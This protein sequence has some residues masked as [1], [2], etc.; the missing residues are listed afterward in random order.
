[1]AY[2]TAKLPPTQ[3]TPHS[4]SPLPAL[5]CV[6]SLSSIFART[7]T[8]GRTCTNQRGESSSQNYACEEWCR[9]FPIRLMIVA[10]SVPPRQALMAPHAQQ[11]CTKFA[12]WTQEEL[13]E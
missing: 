7:L 1:M 5:C 9:S 12:R 4:F 3:C 10:M 11:N 13:K 6:Q 2:S 8:R